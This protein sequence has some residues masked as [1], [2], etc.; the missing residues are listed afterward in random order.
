MRLNTW[1]AL[2]AVVL[3]AHKASAAE[4]PAQD[5]TASPAPAPAGEIASAAPPLGSLPQVELHGSAYFLFYQP[6][7][8]LDAPTPGVKPATPQDTSFGLSFASIE[9]KGKLDEFGGFL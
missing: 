2:G 4:T 6:L 3:W 5:A 9:L 8:T 1:I 7:S